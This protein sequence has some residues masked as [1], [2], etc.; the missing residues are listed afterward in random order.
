MMPPGKKRENS[1]LP[2]A[3]G[4]IVKPGPVVVLLLGL[5]AVLTVGLSGC[6]SSSTPAISV[7]LTSTSTGIDQGQTATLTAS[8]N[9][10]KNAGVQWSVSGGG[11]LSG[12]TTTSATYN[13]PNPVT[14]AFTATVTATSITDPTKSMSLQ[15]RVSPPPVVTSTSLPTATAGTAYSATLS[16]SGGTSPYQWTITSG[17]LPA[18]L[19]LS[20]AGL[21]TG[22]P[23]AASS[24]SVTFK[25]TDAA[26]MSAT[27]AIT[28]TVNP[29]PPLTIT[30]N[31]LPAATIGTAYSQTLQATGGVPSYSWSITAGSLPA[32]LNLSSAGVI[33]GTPTGTLTGA[34]NFT[35]TVTDSQTPTAA[36]KSASLSIVVSEPPLSVTT[37][38]LAGGS[39]GNAYSQTLQAIGGTP[40]YTWS[41]SVGTLPAGLALNASTG[42]ISGTPTTTGTFNFTVKVTDSTAP[43][44]GTATAGLSI[45]INTALAIT[46]TSLPGGSVS[47]PY[48]ATV[49]AT[50]GAQPY[51]W[52]VTS[53]SLPAG[54]SINSTTGVI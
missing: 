2:C 12:Q 43:T 30:T 6:G 40:P 29:P 41:V 9:D 25:V 35:V 4:G 21:I 1:E 38:S 46:T 47:A 7:N 36:S 17:T 39:V 10:S 13:A 33:S 31:S 32:G 5:I 19:S 51:S 49:N 27:Q 54:L 11:T 15:I 37:T 20:R 16:E 53:G 24:G 22:E 45:T 8:V 28:I 44:P 14:S 52:S 3:R 50:G 23:T 42:T 34:I 48:S 26:G 18:G